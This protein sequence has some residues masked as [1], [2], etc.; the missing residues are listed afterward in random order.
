MKA[1]LARLAR[2]DALSAR[3]RVILLAVLLV[4]LWALADA[5]LLTPMERQR[6]ATLSSIVSYRTQLAE[7]Q[8]ELARRQALPDPDAL[9]RQQLAAAEKALA[10]RLQATSELQKTLVTPKDTLRVLQGLLARQ[11]GV[12]L[13][14][15]NT[16]PPQ[17]LGQAGKPVAAEAKPAAQADLP[18]LYKH[19]VQLTVSGDYAALTRYMSVVEALPAGFYWERAS[20]DASHHPHIELSLTL[21]TLS[22]DKTWLSL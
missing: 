6:K 22:L 10:E 16:L 2:L 9:A 1:L 8:A 15:L 7:L 4:A 3:E 5:L 17:P 20:L 18:P 13:I 21:N 14:R 11:P 19:S 12:H